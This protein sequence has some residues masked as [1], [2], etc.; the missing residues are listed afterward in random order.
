MPIRPNLAGRGRRQKYRLAGPSVP[1]R[2]SA[3]FY[4][5]LHVSH[6]LPK[7]SFRLSPALLFS[8][9]LQPRIQFSLLRRAHRKQ[10][11][12]RR[13]RSFGEYS[14]ESLPLADV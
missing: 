12:G 4:G 9:R 5:I 7:T 11:F 3:S 1:R 8:L 6:R 10:I 13:V 14:A 2:N